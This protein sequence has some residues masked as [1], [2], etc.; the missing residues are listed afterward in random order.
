VVAVLTSVEKG[1]KAKLYSTISDILPHF[2]WGLLYSLRSYVQPR[3]SAV[4]AVKDG[5]F[6][7]YLKK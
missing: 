4:S 3:P 2:E 5:G 7:A 1:E 6:S